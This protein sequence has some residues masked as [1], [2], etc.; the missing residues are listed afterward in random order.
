LHTSRLLIY[1]IL[2][3]VLASPSVYSGSEELQAPLCACSTLWLWPNAPHSTLHCKHALDESKAAH[4]PRQPPYTRS[5]LLAR[6]LHPGDTKGSRTMCDANLH[7]GSTKVLYRD[8][9]MM[10][11]HEAGCT[12]A[13]HF[14]FW[15]IDCSELS[16]TRHVHT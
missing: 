12:Y 8:S 9:S 7:A 15:F 10:P 3:R 5:R 4:R 13:A 1:T 14:Q 11:L 6:H 16:R 2:T